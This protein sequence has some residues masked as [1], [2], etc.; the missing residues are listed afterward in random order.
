M[1]IWLS[2]SVPTS[3]Q[4]HK[5]ILTRNY[6]NTSNVLLVYNDFILFLSLLHKSVALFHNGLT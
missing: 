2:Y 5:F 3:R 1:G 4:S 6:Y